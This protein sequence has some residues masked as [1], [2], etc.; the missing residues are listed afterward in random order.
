MDITRYAIKLRLGNYRPQRSWGKLI[1]SV[2]CVKN[3]VHRGGLPHCMLG[4][5][6]PV[7]RHPRDQI[8]LDQTPPRDQTPSWDQTPQ[9][10]RAT[11]GR[12]ASYWNAILLF[13]IFMLI[14][15]GKETIF[16]KELHL[17]KLIFQNKDILGGGRY[18]DSPCIKALTGEQ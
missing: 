6:R 14:I 10:I 7:S 12:Y 17:E 13:C 18:A 5:H 1:F 4:Y 15:H 3:S 9:E 11:S 2:A 16:Q 8:P